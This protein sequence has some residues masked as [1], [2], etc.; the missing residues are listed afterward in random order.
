MSQSSSGNTTELSE[1]LFELANA[2]RLALLLQV[3]TK[4]QRMSSLS[5]AIDAS[6]P[7]CSRHLSRLTS[8][9]LVR[10]NSEGL[11]GTTVMGSTILRLL[12][13]MNVVVQHKEYFKSHDLSEL[14]VGFTQRIG[15]LS[16]AEYRSHFSEV[17]DRIKS[18]VTEAKEYSCL[19]VDK[20]ILVGNVDV[21]DFASKQL[22]ARFIFEEGIHHR[23]LTSVKAAYPRSE[24]ALGKNVKIALGVTEKSAG[25]IFPTADGK[26]DF[27]SGFFGE[28]RLFREWCQDLFEYM[29]ARS[30]KVHYVPPFFQSPF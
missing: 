14:P 19:M 4:E 7:E 13:G 21:T 27:G 17:L 2:D 18:T 20:P 23:V 29:W 25:V 12:P 28:D 11:Y 22:P 8:L 3:A 9:G 10:K 15:A 26:L 16:Q 5:K 6:V 24:L 1:L 30:Q